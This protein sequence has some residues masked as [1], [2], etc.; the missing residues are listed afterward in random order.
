MFKYRLYFFG[1]MFLLPESSFPSVSFPNPSWWD[2]GLPRRQESVFQRRARL[3]DLWCLSGSRWGKRGEWPCCFPAS[4]PFVEKGVPSR[5][6]DLK[7]RLL[8]WRGYQAKVGRRL[9][10]PSESKD[11]RVSYP[12]AYHWFRKPCLTFPSLIKAGTGE[13]LGHNTLLPPFTGTLG[14]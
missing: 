6:V 12:G 13:P 9:G 2:R 8:S 11:K 7:S 3:V 5:Q 10:C 14:I 1:R 4:A